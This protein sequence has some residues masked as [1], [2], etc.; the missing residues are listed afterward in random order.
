MCKPLQISTETFRTAED[1]LGW[2]GERRFFFVRERV[3][4]D[5]E[6][7]GR[8]RLD[9]PGY[10]FRVWVTNRTEGPLELWCN[11]NGRA[12]VKQRIEEL[13]NELGA[14]DSCTQDFCETEA[15]FLAVLFT[16]NTLNLYQQPAT[17]P[18][19]S[20]QP[21]T[22]RTAVFVVGGDSGTARTFG[23]VE[24]LRRL[25]WIGKTPTF[26]GTDFILKKSNLAELGSL[27]SPS[28]L[29]PLSNLI[30]LFSST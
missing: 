10:T 27:R 9:G 7:V 17:P 22:L 15:A 30:P 11:Y 3:R 1:G 20:R 25:G 29:R 5:K 18:A 21:V 6:A 24:P 8:K 16:F 26:A 12:S 4:E 19:G 23:G 28:L 13:K 14:D 2:P